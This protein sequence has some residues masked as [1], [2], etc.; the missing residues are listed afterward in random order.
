MGRC[1]ELEAK[2][3][4]DAERAEAEAAAQDEIIAQWKNFGTGMKSQAEETDRQLQAM[5]ARAE[6]AE[7][8]AA[9]AEARATALQQV[10]EAAA[11]QAAAAENLSTEFHD[12]V[13]ADVWD[14]LSSPL[15]AGDCFEDRGC[16]SGRFRFRGHNPDGHGG[17]GRF[18][19]PLRKLA[20]SISLAPTSM[21]FA[22]PAGL[23]GG[24]VEH[25]GYYPSSNSTMAVSG[26]PTNRARLRR[27][28][29]QPRLRLLQRPEES[30]ADRHQMPLPSR[31]PT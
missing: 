1:E 18:A 25:R 28:I 24:I 11:R 27:W 21:P 16:R 17:V 19:N 3:Q 26:P 14:R 15:G 13:I 4:A 30:E 6:A 29:K 2:M 9:A 20:A 10:S 5:K 22:G 8:R 12:K 31:S 7:A 23:D